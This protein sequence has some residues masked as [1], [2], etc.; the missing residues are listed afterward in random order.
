[1]RDL[2]TSTATSENVGVA[3]SAQIRLDENGLQQWHVESW[4]VPAP[5]L[6]SHVFAKRNAVIREL[7]RP[8]S[9]EAAADARIPA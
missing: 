7:Y 6:E 5:T 4:L 3:A 9:I 8:W 2:T 1:V